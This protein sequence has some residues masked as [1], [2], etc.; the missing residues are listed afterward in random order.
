MIDHAQA[1]RSRPANSSRSQPVPPP[2]VARRHPGP[3]PSH[4]VVAGPSG[5]PSG[6]CR[7]RHTG[8]GSVSGNRLFLDGRVDGRSFFVT[9]QGE[10][11]FSTGIDHVSSNPDT[12]QSTGRCPYCDAIQSQ[13]PSTSAWASA[14]VTQLRSW[15]FNSLGPFTD[16]GTFASLM[17]YSVQL[18]M[19]SGN[20]WFAA[21]FATHADQVAASQVAPLANDR[22]LIGWYTDSELRWGP[23]INTNQPLLD[24]YLALP[25]G[26]P[27][28]A[29]AQQYVG[30]PN[31]FVYALATRYFQVTTAAVRMYDPNHLILG[32]KAEGQYIQ[33]ELLEAASHYV[34]V[35]SI[36]DYQLQPGFA[37]G[38]D[39]LWP[40][41]LPVTP[42]FS[43]FEQYLGSTPIMVA[44]YSFIAKTP[45][46]PN[47]V[48]GVLAVYPDQPARAAAYTD[49]VAP[50]YEN[51]PW[52]VGDEWFEYVDEPQGGRFDGENNNFGVVDVENQPYQDLVTQLEIMH[53]IAPDR[54]YQ[55]GP[56][57]DSW[58]SGPSGVTCTATMAQ[59]SY[60]LSIFSTSLPGATQ[61][62]P[63]ANY[64]VAIGGSPGYTFTLPPGQSLPAGLQLSSS[65]G[66]VSG[67]PSVS[68]TFAFTINV[69]DSTNPASQTASQQVSL[70]IGPEPFAI[71]TATT[72]PDSH[73][74]SDR[75]LLRG[76]VGRPDPDGAVAALR[77]RRGHLG[78]RR[79]ADV[80]LLHLRPGHLVRER[81]EGTGGLHQL[82]RLGHVR[83]R[84]PDRGCSG[85]P[86]H[87]HP[88]TGPD[89]HIGSDRHLLRGGV[90]RPDPDG[91]VAALRGRRGHLGFRRRADVALLHLRPG[92]LVRERLEG[93]GGLHQLGR[94][95]HVQSRH[96]DRGCSGGPKHHHPTTGPDSHI[97][98]DRHLLRGGVGRP[99]PD[100]AVA[101][102]RGRRGHLGFRRRADVALLHLRPGHLVRERLEGTG[103]LHQLG[104]LGHVQS[105]HSDRGPARVVGRPEWRG[106]ARKSR[107]SGQVAVKPARLRPL[108]SLWARIADDGVGL[109]GTQLLGVASDCYLVLNC[110]VR[111]HLLTAS[112]PSGEIRRQGTDQRTSTT[113]LFDA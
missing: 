54:A 73:I 16:T 34:D 89:S 109:V 79:R 64:V 74:G 110:P 7:H 71:T 76:G 62:T 1:H 53:S 42:T 8:D 95:G 91:A 104:R 108:A 37:Q 99:D 75:H 22:N 82:G 20:D 15:G 68:G 18:S 26:S 87:H 50:L 67:N 63:Y 69:S 83:S 35:F 19:A 3:C 70:T 21:S 36:D 86:K 12:D 38:I 48:P 77:G 4:A 102:L 25:A 45:Q 28:L 90:G 49:Y 88:T 39:G 40:Q 17:P 23:D 72:G 80:A 78:F 57:C 56:T 101:A 47:T 44:E 11:F 85:G 41:Y 105:R 24:D 100:G 92:H 30:N 43:N 111:R 65:S 31:G 112:P 61:G 52:V 46:T 113:T 9:P 66:L 2:P 58:A 27:G 93:T 14:T 103:G 60:P 96:P 10:P 84:H 107:V 32:V 29:V 94:L 98:S 13:Y 106:E 6:R 59:A 51:A 55:T 33:P 5:R 97:G 81:L